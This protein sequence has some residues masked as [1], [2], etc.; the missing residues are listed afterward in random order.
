MIWCGDSSSATL[1]LGRM[2]KEDCQRSQVKLS[3]T[4]RPHLKHQSSKKEG[5]RKVIPQMG[6]R[7]E[8]L[9]NW[10]HFCP[11]SGLSRKAS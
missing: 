6:R 11:L 1:A 7:G 10:F 2:R 3:E 8:Q 9:R 4:M 5:K